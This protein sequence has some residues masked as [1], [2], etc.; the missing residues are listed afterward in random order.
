MNSQPLSPFC[1]NALSVDQVSADQV[2]LLENHL[3]QLN[4]SEQTE[5]LRAAAARD[6]DAVRAR[7]RHLN[8]FVREA[9]HVLHPAVPY[10]RNWHIDVI[11]SH[12]EA[13]SRGDYK[14]CDPPRD[15]R[16]LINVPPGSA[17]SLIVSVFWQAWEWGPYDKPHLQYLTTTYREDYA[18]RDSRKTRDL[19]SS[20]WYQALWGDRVKLTNLGEH[21]FANSEQGYRW[22]VPFASLTSGRGDRL[23]I[24]DPH[25]LDSAESD[26]D[27]M[28]VTRRFRE[29]VHDRLNNPDESAIVLIMQRLH[30][31]DLCGVIEQLGLPY[32]K[33]ILPMEYEPERRCETPFGADPREIAGQLLFPQRWSR[34]V[35]NRD[36]KASTAYAWASQ[37][38]QRPQP[39][40]GGMF[41]RAWFKFVNAVPAEAKRCRGW[42]LAAT[43]IK[44]TANPSASG[45]AYTAGVLMAAYAGKYYVE[46]VERFRGT[47]SEV[48]RI[49]YN[50]A[51]CD[52]QGTFISIPQDP[53]QSGVMQKEAYAQLLACFSIRFSPESGSKEDRGLPLAA[54]LE[55]GNV[56]I[57][58][59]GDPDLDA[60]IEPYIEEFTRFPQGYKDQ[61]D[62][63]TRAFGEVLRRMKIANLNG[64]IGGRPLWAGNNYGDGI[65]VAD[66]PND[67]FGGSYGVDGFGLHMGSNPDRASRGND[68][69][70]DM[71]PDCMRDVP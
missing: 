17:K 59:R 62:A 12:L 54:Q 52:P 28:R 46:H 8:G 29:T 58:R 3:Q 40:E 71:F 43:K 7:C 26:T 33:V 9:W 60:W 38:Q 30:I 55:L 2:D 41:K 16:L 68:P 19:I 4:I 35:I 25:S 56:F 6:A 42:D 14:K 64:D 36:K 69:Y 39:R 51:V 11:C 5:Q 1:A 20:E 23:L 10:V 32:T 61:V 13:I 27:R 34:E 37:K 44:A 47:P 50:R 67:G 22:A 45:P 49:I 65:N 53:G 21:R 18:L 15:N 66:L 48:E 63:S 57:V 31:N 24:D 70:A